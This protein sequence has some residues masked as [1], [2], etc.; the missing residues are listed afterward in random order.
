MRD[1]D[2]TRDVSEGAPGLEGRF[3]GSGAS[4]GIRG[5]IF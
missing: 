3:H 2:E 4:D 1:S 5:K